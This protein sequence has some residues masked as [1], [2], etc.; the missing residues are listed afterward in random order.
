MLETVH[1]HGV[2]A[3]PKHG[4]RRRQ[5]EYSARAAHPR[6]VERR[7]QQAGLLARGSSLGAPPSR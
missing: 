2:A 7:L 6:T 5:S 4:Q 3:A 1:E